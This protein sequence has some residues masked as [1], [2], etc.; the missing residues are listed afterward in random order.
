MYNIN[1]LIKI[2]MN[3]KNIFV[4]DILKLLEN[5]FVEAQDLADILASEIKLH[6]KLYFQDYNPHISDAQYD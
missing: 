2:T 1:I 5:N 4:N 3:Q 6:N